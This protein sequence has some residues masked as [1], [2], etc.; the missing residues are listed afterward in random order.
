MSNYFDTLRDVSKG[1]S[2]KKDKIDRSKVTVINNNNSSLMNRRGIKNNVLSEQQQK[3]MILAR[4]QLMNDY[5]L[6][7]DELR[8]GMLVVLYKENGYRNLDKDDEYICCGFVT[9]SEL[10]TSIK[11]FTNKGMI[12]RGYKHKNGYLVPVKKYFSAFTLNYGN[13]DELELSDKQIRLILF[14]YNAFLD[15]K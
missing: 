15:G 11:W 13:K 4:H 14:R 3:E 10:G 1:I 8:N 5:R 2:I 9:K 12:V 6:R 7:D